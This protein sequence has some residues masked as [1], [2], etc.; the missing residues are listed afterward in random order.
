MGC[1]VS[2]V[3][4]L[5]LWVLEDGVGVGTRHFSSFV[6]FSLVLHDG[7]GPHHF[8]GLVTVSLFLKDRGGMRHFSSL[9]TVSLGSAGWGWDGRVCA[10]RRRN[11]HKKDNII[12]LYLYIS[13]IDPGAPENKQEENNYTHESG[14]SKLCRN[15]CIHNFLT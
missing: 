8:S 7:V 14:T 6:T 1:A 15:L 2:P 9:V 4:F 13:H 11:L 10:G 12:S 5:S 3:L